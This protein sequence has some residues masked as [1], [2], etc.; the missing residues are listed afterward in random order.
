MFA[1]SG[2]LMKLVFGQSAVAALIKLATAV[3]SYAMF[4]VLAWVMT[5]TD[6]GLFAVGFNMAIV[7]ASVAGLGATSAILRFIPQYRVQKM[8]G[9]LRGVL[10]EGLWL[11]IVASVVLAA[12]VAALPRLPWLGDFEGIAP[13]AAASLL[14][15]AFAISEYLS[16]VLRT[17]SST[18]WALAPRDI[19]W[20]A[21]I[22]GFGLLAYI[23]GWQYSGATALKITALALL[24][25]VSLQAILIWRPLREGPLDRSEWRR[26]YRVSA[27][28]WAAA[29]LYALTQQMDV[30]IA[31]ALASPADAGA[32]FAAQK[33][34]MLL[35]LVPIAVNIVSAP[36]I[37]SLYHSGDTEG[38][39]RLCV[40]MAL[41]L[42]IPTAI[43]FL[44]LVF[45]GEHLLAM[46][47]PAFAASHHILLILGFAALIAAAAGPTAY[48]MQM[49]GSERHLLRIM[50][51]TYALT[52]ALQFLLGTRFGAVGIAWATLFGA[53]VGNVWAVSVIRRQSGTDTSILN[54]FRPVRS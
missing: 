35:S 19:F 29:T 18:F 10:A 22:L 15:P 34:A 23:L 1:Q 11:T 27:P 42:T 49:T 8:P 20:R 32:Y 5:D 40:W 31:A 38:L 4:V 48:F 37:S 45:A 2:Q 21:A 9:L 51:V 53:A 47:D 14:I 16:S 46:F 54:V 3:L 7:L 36:I 24:V 30:V 52:L 17:N 41:A 6:Y 33:T 44:F 26:W 39:R 25:I 28:M 13:V 50:V 12:V 43:G